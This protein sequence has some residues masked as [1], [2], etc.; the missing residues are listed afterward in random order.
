[1]LKSFYWGKDKK[2]QNLGDTQIPSDM[3]NPFL[4]VC[5]RFFN[6]E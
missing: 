3:G 1:M 6:S 2:C 5:Y 4:S